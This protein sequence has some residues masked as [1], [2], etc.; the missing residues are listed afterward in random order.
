MSHPYRANKPNSPLQPQLLLK[1]K[2]AAPAN[3][4]ICW[5]H[6]YRSYIATMYAKTLYS[7][8]RVEIKKLWINRMV[9]IRTI[10]AYKLTCE[11]VSL[12]TS[13]ILLRTSSMSL[14]MSSIVIPSVEIGGKHVTIT[15]PVFKGRYLIIM[16][17]MSAIN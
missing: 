11:E 17:C 4:N 7:Y 3:T 14:G 2:V 16:H 10:I 1:D 5:N 6:N 12:N 15:L 8:K 9:T 13:I